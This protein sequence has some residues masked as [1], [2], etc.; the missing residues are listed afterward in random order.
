[1]KIF[2]LNIS[3]REILIYFLDLV[4]TV[5]VMKILGDFELESNSV[6]ASH[7]HS[8]VKIQVYEQL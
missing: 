3:K 8:R 6:K 7:Y 4:Y 1:M 5:G 2:N